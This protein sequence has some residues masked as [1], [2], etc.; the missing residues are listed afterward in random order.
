MNQDDGAPYDT[1]AHC[2][3]KEEKTTEQKA[4]SNAIQKKVK[5]TR[6]KYP[7]PQKPHNQES[8]YYYYF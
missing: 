8:Q 2:M 6:R 3:H 7:I 1:E 4:T 5:K